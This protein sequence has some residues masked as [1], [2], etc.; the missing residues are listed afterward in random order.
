VADHWSN[1]FRRRSTSAGF[2]AAR[3][4][5]ATYAGR[6][7]GRRGVVGSLRIHQAAASRMST[8][9]RSPSIT[10]CAW[11]GAPVQL[12]RGRT[13]SRANIGIM[14]RPSRFCGGDCAC[15]SN[16]E[17]SAGCRGLRRASRSTALQEEAAGQLAMKGTR[18]PPSRCSRLKPLR[19]AL[20]QAPGDSRRN[21]CR[22]GRRWMCFVDTL[23][24]QHCDGFRRRRHR[25]AE[26]HRSIRCA[27]RDLGYGDSGPGTS[28]LV[29]AWKRSVRRVVRHRAGMRIGSLL[30][31]ERM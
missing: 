25:R 5:A 21:R 26:T 12:A 2:C 6:V 27:F 22:S 17:Q 28:S 13:S 18:T 19:G 23:R 3:F 31:R 20:V 15:S 4:H 9:S 10:A 16:Q 30:C 11:P 1:I 8:A 7:R 29:L 24:R 14:S